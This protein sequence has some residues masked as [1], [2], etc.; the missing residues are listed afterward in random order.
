M[1]CCEICKAAGDE[2]AVTGTPINWSE[3]G[4]TVMDDCP[5][6]MESDYKA[7]EIGK[8]QSNDGVGNIDD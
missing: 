7:D 3:F 8:E 2:C 6:K 1:I 4:I 5:E